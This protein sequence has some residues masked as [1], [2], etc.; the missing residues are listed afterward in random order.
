M[1]EILQR[2]GPAVAWAILLFVLS[3]ISDLTAPVLI[4]TWDDK[5]HHAAAYVPLGFLLLR[6]I[7]GKGKCTR[8]ALWLAI[9]IGALYGVSDEIHQYFVPGR[10][11]DWTDAVADAVGV[12]LGSGI[13]YKWRVYRLS[14]QPVAPPSRFKKS[15]APRAS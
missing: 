14:R 10:L 7:V 8:Q 4:F 11:M 1:K 9:I 3:S 2:Y 15:T 5:I 13:F 12:T 6:G